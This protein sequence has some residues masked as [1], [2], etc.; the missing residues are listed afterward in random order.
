MGSGLNFIVFGVCAC[1]T[2]RWCTLCLFGAGSHALH[3]AGFVCVH[4][5]RLT[6]L[7]GVAGVAAALLPLLVPV[8]VALAGM[9]WS[10]WTTALLVQAALA[11]VRW[12]PVVRA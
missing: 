3:D 2:V 11:W 10:L 6:S 7:A 4:V 8:A 1:P 12:A 9:W 5:C